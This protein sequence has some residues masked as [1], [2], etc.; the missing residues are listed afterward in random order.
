LISVCIF[1]S[2]YLILT[3]GDV[4]VIV[5]ECSFVLAYNNIEYD[6]LG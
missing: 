5:P 3:T 2:A 4:S 6:I 1:L